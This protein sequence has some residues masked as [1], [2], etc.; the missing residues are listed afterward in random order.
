[1]EYNII[2]SSRCNSFCGIIDS[3]YSFLIFNIIHKCFG[4]FMERKMANN[5]TALFHAYST[6]MFCF[7]YF[8]S[9][10]PALWYFVKKF[11]T[12]YFLYDLRQL[13]KY[14][15]LSLKNCAYLYHH[16]ASIYFWH[17][18][19]HLYNIADVFFWSELSNI[20]SYFVYFYMKQK[21]PNG[22]KL[23]W[24]KKIQL[25]VFSF[26]RLPIITYILIN[27]YH[28]RINLTPVYPVIPNYLMGLIWTNQLRKQL[29]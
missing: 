19:R 13:I 21:N 15:K 28:N 7:S 14:E 29:K 1:M 16:L 12:G 27:I 9:K 20:P 10:D 22:E 8:L 4:K 18:N 5:F 23:K 25:Y 17:Q 2:Q 26:I 3:Y 11:S 24:L 6:A